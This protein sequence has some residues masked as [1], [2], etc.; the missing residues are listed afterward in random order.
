MVFLT[1]PAT[2]SDIVSLGIYHPYRGGS[3]P[4]FDR[5][6]SLILSLK[7]QK[8]EGFAYFYKQLAPLFRED[9]AV[10]VV[11]SHDPAKST[12]GIRS[13][14]KLLAHDSSRV[15]ASAC[16]QRVIKIDKL[17]TGGDRSVQKHLDSIRV[18]Q[19]EL[20]RGRAVL[21][22]DDVTTTHNS[23]LACRTLLLNAGAT[24]VQAYALAQT[25]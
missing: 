17:A 18:A 5:F 23:L 11:P 22:L 3:N 13:L 6:S 4:D 12:S 20:I 24:S 2:S 9:I 7:N 19:P 15:D 1:P 21:L 16:L 25:Q 14:A 8:D 10:A